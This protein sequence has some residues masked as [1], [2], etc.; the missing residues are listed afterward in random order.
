MRD[1]LQLSKQEFFRWLKDQMEKRAFVYGL[2]FDKESMKK[3]LYQLLF[4]EQRLTAAEIEQHFIP[5]G[6][7]GYL[8]PRQKFELMLFVLEKDYGDSCLMLKEMKVRT[9]ITS[10]EIE[11]EYLQWLLEERVYLSEEEKKEFFV[12]NLMDALGLGVFEVLKRAAP[13]GFFVGELCPPMYENENVLKRIAVYVHGTVVRLPF[14][15][16]ISKEEL[17]RNIK[18]A[19]VMEKKGELTMLEP[20][21]D[22]VKEDGTCITAVRPPAGKDWGIRILYN[23]SGKDGQGWNK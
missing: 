2:C 10:E 4:M 12:Q 3:E 6:Q 14:L 17:V 16:M 15:E 8:S 23:T 13:N 5:F 7:A 11:S 20:I 19:L 9:A 21:L 1:I 18:Y 22:F